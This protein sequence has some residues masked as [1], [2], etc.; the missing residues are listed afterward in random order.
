MKGAERVGRRIRCE[1]GKR[2]YFTKRK[3]WASGSPYDRVREKRELCELKFSILRRDYLR[4]RLIIL[5]EKCVKPVR[6]HIIVWFVSRPR[7]VGSQAKSL[8]TMSP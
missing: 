8:V 1:R 7:E 6:H 4:G 3:T 2:L 5:D